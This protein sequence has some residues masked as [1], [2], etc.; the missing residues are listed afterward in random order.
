[1]RTSE[2]A[3]ERLWPPAKRPDA[4]VSRLALGILNRA[5]LDLMPQSQKNLELKKWQ[6]DALRW[7]LS[8]ESQ[9]GSLSWVCAALKMDERAIQQWI[10]ASRREGFRNTSEL[11]RLVNRRWVGP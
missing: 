3:S 9:P 4:P 6:R 10:L 2:L 11:K 1:M 5:F 7:F 8:H